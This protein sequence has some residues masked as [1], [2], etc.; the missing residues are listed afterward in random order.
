MKRFFFICFTII[1]CSPTLPSPE[2]KPRIKDI[3]NSKKPKKSDSP[4]IKKPSTVLSKLLKSIPVNQTHIFNIDIVDIDDNPI[5]NVEFEADLELLGSVDSEELLKNITIN[6]ISDI[7][8]NI[9]FDINHPITQNKT[10]YSTYTFVSYS[11]YKEDYIDKS[12]SMNIYHD[13]KELTHN[14]LRKKELSEKIIMVK[15]TDFIG[16]SF[17]LY[18]KEAN[19]YSA[20]IKNC[21][22]TFILF[23]SSYG[24]LF[25]DSVKIIKD[26]DQLFLEFGFNSSIQLIDSYKSIGRRIG[27]ALF[28][29]NLNG[30]HMRNNTGDLFICSIEDI[31]KVLKRE[32]S[33]VEFLL[34]IK[35]G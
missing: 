30:V 18:S 14:Y 6:K 20:D 4:I 15:A 19:L 16:S 9:I 33:E 3:V 32:I 8:G 5:R 26:Q 1:S 13:E 28:Y 23:S 31:N 21:I 11:I 24:K 10:T 7:T 29:S 25:K 27:N 22:E 35:K 2:P 12:G 17:Y 34:R